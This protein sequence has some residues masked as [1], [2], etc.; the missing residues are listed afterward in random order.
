[1]QLYLSDHLP[2]YMLEFIDYA[3]K[4]LGLDKLRGEIMIDYERSLP[5]ESYGECFGDRSE[6]AI[7]IARTTFGVTISREDKLKTL[8]HE[9]TH[10]K[11][12]LTGKLKCDTDITEESKM[13]KSVW[14]GKTYRYKPENEPKKPWEVEAVKF[15][16]EIYCKYLEDNL[17]PSDS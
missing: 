6:V 15:E 13:W 3:V 8:A 9:L 7:N 1:M 17:C 12:Y 10:A 14:E 4:Y 11:Q 2:K 5:E 16:N